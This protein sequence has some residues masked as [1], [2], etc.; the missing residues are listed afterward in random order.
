MGGGKGCGGACYLGT[1]RGGS[2]C[3]GKLSISWTFLRAGDL[4]LDIQ[5]TI[6]LYVNPLLNFKRRNIV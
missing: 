2:F 3:T 5:I 4:V 1:K 6:G